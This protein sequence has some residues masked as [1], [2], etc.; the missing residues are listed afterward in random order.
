MNPEV[1]Q[2][3]LMT[4]CGFLFALGGTE[5]SKTIKGNKWI[6]RFL[7]PAVVGGICF[8]TGFEW[9]RLA[10]FVATQT[11]S[12][13]LGYGEKLPYW[14]KLLTA[15]A[16]VLPSLFF[17][18]SQWQLLTPALFVLMFFLSNL[19]FTSSLFKWKFVE[20]LTGAFIGITI[21]DLIR[22]TY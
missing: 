13:H 16:Y 9:W 1:Y 17:G 18:L 7:L 12:L 19:R 5:I 2:I 15:I 3:L 11:A 22:M 6:R 20:F 10:A 21:S 8:F 14:R 4:V